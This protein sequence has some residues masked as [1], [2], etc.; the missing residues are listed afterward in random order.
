MWSTPPAYSGKGRPKIHGQ[1]FRLNDS[2]SWWEPEQT[3]ESVEPKLGKIR[4]KK[5]D[6]L[7]FR[8]SSKHPMT[9]ILVERLETVT[10]R[11]NSQPLWLVWVG[12]QMPSL[13]EIWQLY[14]GYSRDTILLAK[15]FLTFLAIA[16]RHLFGHK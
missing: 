7:H 9:L 11:L 5:W 8:G 14:L 3:L 1:Q 16:K 12:I 6:D 13:A 15:Y 2:Q 4:L 10:G